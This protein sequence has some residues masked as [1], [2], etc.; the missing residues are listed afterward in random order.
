MTVRRPFPTLAPLPVQRDLEGVV[1]KLAH[2]G[3]IPGS[4]AAALCFPRT[5]SAISQVLFF[6]PA[7]PLGYRSRGWI[8]RDS[9]RM[10]LLTR[11]TFL[12]ATE[13]EQTVP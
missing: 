3:A 1:A 2:F 5:R 10:G 8:G 7:V 12:I 13:V 11:S 6:A 9:G 4:V